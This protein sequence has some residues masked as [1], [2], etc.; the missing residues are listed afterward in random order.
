MDWE[1]HKL[2]AQVA[3]LKDVVVTYPTCT[4]SNAITQME[5]RIKKKESQNDEQ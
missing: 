2:R 4:I 3:V 5:A 1:L